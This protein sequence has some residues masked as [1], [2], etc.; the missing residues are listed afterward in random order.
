MQLKTTQ[1]N[2]ANVCENQIKQL[3]LIA[4]I[5][6]HFL[7]REGIISARSARLNAS[8]CVRSSRLF[9]PLRGG[10]KYSAAVLREPLLH[11]RPR[12]I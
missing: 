1:A 8:A 3:T 6:V 12:Q 2:L 4:I 7:K 5:V 10:S 11:S 9:W